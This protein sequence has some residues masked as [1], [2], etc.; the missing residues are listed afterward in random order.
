MVVGVADHNGW[1]VLV[2]VAAVKSE[3]MVV[4]RRRVPLIDGGV[5]SQ[6]YHHETLALNNADAEQL[7]RRVKRS[8]AGCAALAFDQLAADLRPRFRVS[9]IAIRQPPLPGLPASVK[10]A[11]ASYYVTCRADGMLYHSALTAAAAHLGWTVAL[12]Q[13]GEEL[14][15]AVEVLT[16]RAPD[17][18]RFLH[19]P[20]LAL[21]PPWAAEH[22]HAFAAAIGVLGGHAKLRISRLGVGSRS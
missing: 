15:R 16:A 11:H 22:R 3:P 1:A 12:Y 19:Q 9:S 18:E 17:V 8:I 4:D 2:S 14:A 6:P 10:D 21:G 13:R 20:R 5:P 7:L